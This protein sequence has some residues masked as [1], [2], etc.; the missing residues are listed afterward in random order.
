MPKGLHGSVNHISLTVSD[1][2]TAMAFFQPL[3]AFLG[4]KSEPIGDY[5]PSGSKICVSVNPQNGTAINIWQA[6]EDHPFQ[7]YEPGLHHLA[8]NTDS[9]KKVDEAAR[10][11]PEWGGRV[12]DGPAEFPFAA[13]GYYAVYFL[14]PDDLK[15]ELVYMPALTKL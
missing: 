6:T 11:T 15:L 5:T 7:V 4:Y 14:G 12:T 8:L 9:K 2:E 10:L 3:L 13:D 1:I